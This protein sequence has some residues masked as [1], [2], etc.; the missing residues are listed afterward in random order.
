[1]E[2]KLAPKKWGRKWTI[3]LDTSDA[4]APQRVRSYSFEERVHLAGH[5]MVVL[6]RVA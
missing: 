5:A 1:M 6:R 2:F 3:I 4:T